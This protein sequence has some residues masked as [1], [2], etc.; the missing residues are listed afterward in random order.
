ML[1]K[2]R[3]PTWNWNSV[4]PVGVVAPFRYLDSNPK[5][6]LPAYVEA[7]VLYDQGKLAD[8]LPFFEQAVAELQKPGAPRLSE[9]YYYTGDTFGRLERYPEA[10]QAFKAAIAQAQSGARVIEN[11]KRAVVQFAGARYPRRSRT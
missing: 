4:W 8:A 1:W 2:F 3:L 7:R 9:L 10:E 6:P 11:V 5:L